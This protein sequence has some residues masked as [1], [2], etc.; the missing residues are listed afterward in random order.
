[1]GAFKTLGGAA[2]IACAWAAL[3]RAS[4]LFEVSPGLSFFFP[5]AAITILAGVRLR[6][7][8]VAAVFFAPFIAPWGAAAGFTKVA[9][10]SVPGALWAALLVLLGPPSGSTWRR[11]V[12]LAGLGIGGGGLISAALGGVLLVSL[13]GPATW[14]GFARTTI[15]WLVPDLAAALV[16]GLPLLVVFAP[17][18]LLDGED[19]ALWREWRR[20][21]ALLVEASAA[22]AV[23]LAAIVGLA[24]LTGGS[25]HW[26]VAFLVFPVAMAAV[27]GGLGGALV[28]NG[29]VAAC[30]LALALSVPDPGLGEVTQRLAPTYANLLL[31][32]L[33]AVT[34]GVLVGREHRLIAQVRRQGRELARGLE[35]TVRAL[36]TAMEAKDRISDRHVQRVVRLA[37]LVGRELGLGEEELAVL[38]RAA[39]LHDVGKIGVPE[40]IL[41]KPGPL[42]PEEWLHIRRHVDIGVEILEQVEFLRPVLDIVRYHQERWDG[43]RS[44]RFPGYHGLKGEEIPRGARIIAAVDAYDAMT[45]D[46]PYRRA[47]TREEAVAEL[48]RGAGSQFDPEVVRVL[49]GLLRE[50]WD[51]VTPDPEISAEF[52]V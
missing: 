5:A 34:A 7:V 11:M 31:L 14:L 32:L 33:I 52:V 24:A 3:N 43:Q 2:L 10:F 48:W 23:A 4:S 18:S 38:R 41:N 21:P 39:M 9:M 20:S 37:V 16:F 45:H 22:A 15:G 40:A 46:R 12:R 49:T 19:E 27:R 30:Y 1:M 29:G 50:E 44:G 17:P 28:V 35:S 36:A 8:G 26:F 51:R 6:W 42:D 13:V 47:V 25:I